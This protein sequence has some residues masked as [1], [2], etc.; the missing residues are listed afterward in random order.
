MITKRMLLLSLCGLTCLVGC[1]GTSEE[2]RA[3]ESSPRIL[4]A[5]SPASFISVTSTSPFKGYSVLKENSY[6]VGSTAGIEGNVVV[7]HMAV[8][9]Y[10]KSML[11]VNATSFYVLGPDSVMQKPVLSSEA[12]KAR[13][14]SLREQHA[15][16]TEKL[17]TQLAYEADQK[18]RQEEHKQDN[19]N[20]AFG[21]LDMVT[22]GTSSGIQTDLTHIEQQIAAVESSSEVMLQ[23]EWKS[24]M[25]PPGA[26]AKGLLA[27]Q[28]PS[29]LPLTLHA[30]VGGQDFQFTFDQPTPSA[31]ALPT[32]K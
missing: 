23:D 3:N 8:A 17:K 6:V 29:N 28:A 32:P 30:S 15:E 12:A 5:M 25:I 13:L 21:L 1:A 4:A 7:A 22:G 20:G 24:Q 26:I 9:N 14:K 10:S 16:L 27:W 19:V 11:Q 18:K 2:S 31:S